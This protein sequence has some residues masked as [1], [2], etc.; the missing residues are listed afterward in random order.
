MTTTIEVPEGYKK[1][2]K[3]NLIPLANIKPIDQAR[4]DLVTNIVQKAYVIQE[5]LKLFKTESFGDITAF[6]DLSAEQYGASLGGKKGN[7]TLT[8][9]DGEH[10]VKIAISD[11]LVF[12]ERLQIAKALIHECLFEWTEGARKEIKSLIDDAFQVD[13]EG[14]INQYRLF[15]LQ[16]IESDS[17]KWAQAMKAIKDSTQVQSSTEYLRLYKRNQAGKYDQISMDLAGV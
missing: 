1:D 7:L 8:S 16:R 4:D 2:A 11:R 6:L 17:E 3:N 15:A 9:F 5:T 13:K 14:N 12:D 10:Q